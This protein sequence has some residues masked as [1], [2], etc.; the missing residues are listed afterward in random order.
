MNQT[1]KECGGK[2]CKT[3]MMAFDASCDQ[4]FMA[5]RGRVMTT[6]NKN[7]VEWFIDAPCKHLKDGRCTI[8]EDRPQSC[9]TYEVGGVECKV[10][11]GLL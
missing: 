4:A 11:R 8:Y 2:C 10:T 3:I 7:I 6:N 1:C 5:T 9:R